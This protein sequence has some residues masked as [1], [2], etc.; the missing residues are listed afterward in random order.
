MSEEG[1]DR[2][3]TPENAQVDPTPGIL[4]PDEQVTD[5]PLH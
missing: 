5:G 4:N 1:S 3:D 2:G